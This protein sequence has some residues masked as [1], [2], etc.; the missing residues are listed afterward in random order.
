MIFS[1]Q[2]K[3]L[4]IL[5]NHFSLSPRVP[6][7]SVLVFSFSAHLLL[8]KHFAKNRKKKVSGIRISVF[9]DGRRQSRFFS[10]GPGTRKPGRPEI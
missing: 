7:F 9:K 6:L 2:I 10:P 8:T 3:K 4:Q 1:G 5:Q